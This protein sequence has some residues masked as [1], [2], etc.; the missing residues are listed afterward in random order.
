[1]KHAD[2]MQIAFQASS[3]WEQLNHSWGQPLLKHHV[4]QSDVVLQRW[5][6]TAAQRNWGKFEKRLAWDGW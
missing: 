4:Q 1:V 5:C 6:E 2:L 3:L